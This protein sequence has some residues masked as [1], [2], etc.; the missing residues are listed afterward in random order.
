M[1]ES[2]HP[3]T[4]PKDEPGLDSELNVRDLSWLTVGLLVILVVAAV[5]VWFIGFGIRD[6]LAAEDPPPPA[7]PEARMPY[8]PPEPHLQVD[9]RQQLLDLRAAEEEI[10]STHGWVDETNGLTRIPIDQAMD[11]IVEQGLPTPVSAP[12][13]SEESPTGN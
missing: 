6:R 1:T 7:L 11:L 10:L 9:P 12:E 8:Q 5:V 4:G 13:P 3:H 2:Q